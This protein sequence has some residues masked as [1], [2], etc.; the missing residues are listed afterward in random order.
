[1][2]ESWVFLPPPSLSLR[3]RRRKGRGR[4]NRS[5]VPAGRRANCEEDEDLGDGGAGGEVTSVQ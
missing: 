3:P 5:D 2:K 4:S 1:M